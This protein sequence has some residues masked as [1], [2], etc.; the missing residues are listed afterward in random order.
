[1]FPSRIERQ[2]LG[3]GA[4]VTLL[5]ALI[6]TVT[7]AASATVGVLVGGIV[8][9]RGQDHQWSRDQQLIAYQEFLGHYAKFT[10]VIKRAHADR[11]GWDYDWAEWSA[12]LTRVGLIAP[13]EVAVEVDGFGQS[14]DRFLDRVAREVDPARAP[15]GEEEFREASAE[16]ARS[17]IRLVNA[18]RRSLGGRRKPLT[19][20]IGGSHARAGV[21]GSSERSQP[22]G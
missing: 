3:T 4:G 19:F 10:M 11:R 7:G 9:R 14:V 15:L 17:Q 18:M 16:V 20:W 8:T 5:E 12:V 6:T 21:R 13:P 1:M 22:L 2:L